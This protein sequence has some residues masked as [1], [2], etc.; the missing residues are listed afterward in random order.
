M[1]PNREEIAAL[2]VKS[3]NQNKESLKKQF[4]QSKKNIGYFYL[5]NLLPDDLCL[6]IH[7][8]FPK[9]SEAELKKDL[10]EFKYI[11]YQMNKYDALL[12]EV[13]YA[14][15]N[16]AVVE[17]IS[18]ICNIKQLIPDNKL[19]AGGL[20]MMS[21]GNYL[22]PHLDNSHDKDRQ[23]WRVLNL[24]YYVTPDWSLKNGGNLEL[25]TNGIRQRPL[26]LTS[27]FNRLIVMATHQNSWHSVNNVKV[28]G[29]RCCVSNYYFSELPLLKEDK[30][31]VTLFR[32]RATEK[33]RDIILKI[34]NFVR[35][36]VRRIFKK[37]I[38]ENPHQYKK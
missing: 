12:E 17:L 30:F 29:I 23:L 38:R 9:L 20:S 35:S 8:K 36:N 28:N 24:L 33:G 19:Y 4:L 14:F 3:L 32:G 6:E 37:G 31:H 34:D 10:R 18:E 22:K 15:Q 5:D 1:K 27:K 7:D 25:W 16:S 26:E 13:I 11:A 2:I 21:K